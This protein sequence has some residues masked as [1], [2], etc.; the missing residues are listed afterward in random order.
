[1][2]KK[3]IAKVYLNGD[4]DMGF[5]VE[6]CTL[7]DHLNI[8]AGFVSSAVQ[9]M[10]NQKIPAHQSADLLEACMR[11]GLKDGIAKI[12]AKNAEKKKCLDDVLNDIKKILED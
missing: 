6:D 7:N 5:E 4:E 1:M 10:F 2:E 12:E 9:R 11:Q 3:I 8:I